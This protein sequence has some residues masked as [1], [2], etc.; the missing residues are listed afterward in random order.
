M[1]TEL[2]L[3]CTVCD[4]VFL[5]GTAARKDPRFIVTCPRCGSTDLLRVQ[6]EETL[7]PSQGFA[8]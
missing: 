5:V 4:E 3:V 1:S 8:A 6:V 7:S 2:E